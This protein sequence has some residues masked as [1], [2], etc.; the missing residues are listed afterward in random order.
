MLELNATLTKRVAEKNKMLPG[1]VQHELSHD[2]D[3][4]LDLDSERLMY[5]C[6]GLAIEEGAG[7]QRLHMVGTLTNY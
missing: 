7:G 4:A 3:L 5:I 6:E 2:N 1:Q